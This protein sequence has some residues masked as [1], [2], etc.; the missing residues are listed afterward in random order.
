MRSLLTAAALL[1]CAMTAQAERAPVLEL[2]GML[3]VADEAR[4]S[5]D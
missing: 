3:P 4:W 2:K 1:F 5:A